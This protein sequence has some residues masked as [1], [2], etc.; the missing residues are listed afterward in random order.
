MLKAQA[1]HWTGSMQALDVRLRQAVTIVLMELGSADVINN[2]P[3]RFQ[4]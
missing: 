2:K 1:S 3:S 4:T